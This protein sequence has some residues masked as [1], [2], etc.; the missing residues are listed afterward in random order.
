M[1]KHCGYFSKH[2]TYKQTR[3]PSLIKL[4]AIC[5]SNGKW[6]DPS[7]NNRIKVCNKTTIAV[8]NNWHNNSSLCNYFHGKIHSSTMSVILAQKN[9]PCGCT[10]TNIISKMNGERM[11]LSLLMPSSRALP[12]RKKVSFHLPSRLSL[13]TLLPS[14][15]N[16]S[17]SALKDVA[18]L[19]PPEL[20]SSCQS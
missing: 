1:W 11:F 12:I 9:E 7:A 16:C 4:C 14:Q 3:E 17:C 5:L 2:W 13:C 8:F 20:A 15:S 19:F 18:V 10:I 6:N